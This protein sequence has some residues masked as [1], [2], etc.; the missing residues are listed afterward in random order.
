ML[1]SSLGTVHVGARQMKLANL[2]TVVHEV[3]QIT[4]LHMVFEVFDNEEDAVCSFA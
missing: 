4:K 2:S 1:I 3:I